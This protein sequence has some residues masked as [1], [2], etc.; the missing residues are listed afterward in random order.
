MVYSQVLERTF[1]KRPEVIDVHVVQNDGVVVFLALWG[2]FIHICECRSRF[3]EYILRNA[4][5]VAFY[6]IGRS[7][8]SLRASEERTLS[9][10]SDVLYLFLD[11]AGRGD[12]PSGLAGRATGSFSSPEYSQS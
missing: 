7:V 3:R 2:E 1:Q 8:D 6:L 4:E 12:S 9:T 10:A 5:Q 11:V